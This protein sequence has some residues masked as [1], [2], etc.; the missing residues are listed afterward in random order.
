MR[1]AIIEELASG[2]V[3]RD[4]PEP[5]P[6]GDEVLVEVAAS[7]VNSMD[8]RVADGLIGG[9]LPYELPITLGFDVAGTVVAAGHDVTTL[10]VGDPA[11]AD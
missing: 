2:P 1:A 6:V 9:H 10:Q 7:S 5:V 11:P 4:V 8:V 3:L